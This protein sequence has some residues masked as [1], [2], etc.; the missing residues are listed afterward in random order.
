MRNVNIRS[1]SIGKFE[2]TQKQWFAVMGTEPSKFKGGNLPVEQVSWNDAQEFV[3][4]LS[5]KTGKQY[6][7]PTEAEWEYA[8]RAGSQTMYFF[9]DDASQLERYA[10]FD[11]NTAK[12]FQPLFL[13]NLLGAKTNPVGEKLPNS[14]GL[15]DIYGNVSEWTQDCWN[16]NYNGAPRD[17]SA[18]AVGDCR[19]RVL[20]GGPMALSADL[21]TSY[22]RHRFSRDQKNY[23]TGLRV[24]RTP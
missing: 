6:R 5:Q 1:F 14:F 9:G 21:L 22:T 15:H 19:Q 2:V 17:G 18:W 8:A 3:Q 20:R 10:W 7:L 23:M 16:E 11:K 4:N 24:A 13:F 12:V